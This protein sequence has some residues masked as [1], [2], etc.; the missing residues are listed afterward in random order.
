MAMIH[1]AVSTYRDIHRGRRVI[2]CT[3]ATEARQGTRYVSTNPNSRPWQSKLTTLCEKMI[4]TSKCCGG[5]ETELARLR[6][7]IFHTNAKETLA[8]SIYWQRCTGMFV[9]LWHNHHPHTTYTRTLLT[10]PFFSRTFMSRSLGI[11]APDQDLPLGIF[12]YACPPPRGVYIAE[13]LRSTV[14]DCTY[15]L[16]IPALVNTPHFALLFSGPKQPQPGVH[17]LTPLPTTVFRRGPTGT[18]N[19]IEDSSTSRSYTN[20]G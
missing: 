20:S 7:T 9:V 10:P 18:S 12:A 1:F 3:D 11:N 5:L 4:Q 14:S 16:M 13:F 15:L 19:Y 8:T 2:I 17:M 6:R